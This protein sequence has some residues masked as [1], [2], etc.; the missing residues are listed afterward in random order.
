M[1]IHLWLPL[2]TTF[3]TLPALTPR[4]MDAGSCG[5]Q[6]RT[7]CACTRWGLPCLNC[8]QLSGAL[9]PHHFTLTPPEV[10]KCSLLSS[11]ALLQI[12]T[13]GGGG[14]FSVALAL[15]PRPRPVGVTHHRV[16]WCSDFP[17]SKTSLKQRSSVHGGL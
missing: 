2:P 16:L 12:T 15:A 10:V 14:I 9:L 13:S 3:S 8:H 1:T 11:C 7:A 4:T 17:P 6:R 5:V